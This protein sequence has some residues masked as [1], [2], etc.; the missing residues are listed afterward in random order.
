MVSTRSPAV[1]LIVRRNAPD[2]FDAL[3]RALDD[4]STCRV[5]LDRRVRS[6]AIAWQDRRLERQ[7]WAGGV[8]VSVNG[9]G[10]MEACW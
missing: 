7:R 8:L 2:L 4:S 10:A 1:L 9:T 6:E 3:Q 5:L